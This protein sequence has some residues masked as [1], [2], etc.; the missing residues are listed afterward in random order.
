MQLQRDQLPPRSRCSFLSNSLV[1]LSELK[2]SFANN[3]YCITELDFE[4]FDSDIV[5]IFTSAFYQVDDSDTL[6]FRLMRVDSTATILGSVSV[7]GIRPVSDYCQISSDL[8]LG[9]L[10]LGYSLLSYY[11][12]TFTVSV[13]FVS[14]GK[15]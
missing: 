4:W 10:T 13:S 8:I 11:T 14:F 12:T 5:Y 7:N 15:C 6:G 9:P 2:V 3:G 1:A